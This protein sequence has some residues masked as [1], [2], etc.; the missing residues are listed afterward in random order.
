M[1]NPYCS[2]KLL[3]DPSG[4]Q[5][6]LSPAAFA[7]VPAPRLLKVQPRPA[8]ALPMENPYCSCKLTR[9]AAAAQVP[10]PAPALPRHRPAAG[11]GRIVL[12]VRPAAGPGGR[13]EG[14][15]QPLQ[16]PHSLWIVPMDSPFCSCKADTA[17]G[18][19]VVYVARDPK[20]ACVSA[21][22]HKRCD[23]L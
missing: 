23:G 7:A 16:P 11:P 17:A 10:R 6:E 14:A 3:T 9:W 22:H 19:E 5:A 20:D 2:C 15:P 4:L 21:F 13:G 18:A 8:A 1:E 12:G